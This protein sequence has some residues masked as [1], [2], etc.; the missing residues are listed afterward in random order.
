MYG[1]LFVWFLMWKTFILFMKKVIHHEIEIIRPILV[2]NFDFW[3]QKLVDKVV[4]KMWIL[5]R[6]TRNIIVASKGHVDWYSKAIASQGNSCYVEPTPT[7]LVIVA[8]IYLMQYTWGWTRQWWEAALLR[9]IFEKCAGRLQACAVD[10]SNSWDF[11]VKQCRQRSL[12]P[13]ADV[14]RPYRERYIFCMHNL[15]GTY[16]FQQIS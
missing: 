5:F 6:R 12:G 9:S 3:T 1:F 15:A 4:K 7:R 8:Y 11:I 2:L 14:P 16:S 10:H 13:S